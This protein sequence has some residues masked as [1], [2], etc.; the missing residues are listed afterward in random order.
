[1]LEKKPWYVFVI[2]SWIEFITY[3]IESWIE[4]I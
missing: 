4:S 3:N 2:E 1:M